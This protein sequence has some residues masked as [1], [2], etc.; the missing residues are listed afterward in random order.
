MLSALA[1]RQILAEEIN[2]EEIAKVDPGIAAV[3]GDLGYG[4]GIKGGIARKMLKI[5]H[6]N[7]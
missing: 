6:S 4:M 7:N 3:A 5:L 2:L 1:A